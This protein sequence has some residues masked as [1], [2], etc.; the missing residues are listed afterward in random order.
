MVPEIKVVQFTAETE[1]STR[2]SNKLHRALE[3][4]KDVVWEMLRY[5]HEHNKQLD[6]YEAHRYRRMLKGRVSKNHDTFLATAR[7]RTIKMLEHELHD[8]CVEKLNGWYVKKGGW[9]LVECAKINP[10]AP[11]SVYLNLSNCDKPRVE[12]LYR[13]EEDLEWATTNYAVYNAREQ[14][15][16]HA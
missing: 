9:K 6:T 8:E 11:A 5:C 12:V 1:V 16:M 13:T 4:F 3:T 2:I 7:Q 15:M 14:E 10:V